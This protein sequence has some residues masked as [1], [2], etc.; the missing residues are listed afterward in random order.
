LVSQGK[1]TDAPNYINE[2]DGV[3]DRFGTG[4][5]CQRHG[6]LQGIRGCMQQIMARGQCMMGRLRTIDQLITPDSQNQTVFDSCVYTEYLR[7]YEKALH[8]IP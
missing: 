2:E 7:K 8:L 3:C 4:E 1:N 5:Q 6:L